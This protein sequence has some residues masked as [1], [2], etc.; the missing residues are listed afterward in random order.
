MK[1]RNYKIIKKSVE[2]KFKR[3]IP[4]LVWNEGKQIYFGF[5]KVCITSRYLN[6]N[7]F[8]TKIENEN[9]YILQSFSNH[10]DNYRKEGYSFNHG[11]F[12]EKHELYEDISDNIDK[13]KQCAEK[14]LLEF[15][16]KGRKNLY[17][18]DYHDI[19][20]YFNFIEFKKKLKEWA[21]PHIELLNL[22][23]IK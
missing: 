12:N 16:K 7:F 6:F 8:I 23:K 3:N 4:N 13:L 21:K 19:N 9:V 18:R 2:N 14:F 5:D 1:R 11:I 22:F 20:N 17:V 15:Y 10:W